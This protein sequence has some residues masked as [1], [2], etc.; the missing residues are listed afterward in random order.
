MSDGCIQHLRSPSLQASI[1]QLVAITCTPTEAKQGWVWS[2]SGWETSWEIRCCC[3]KS[4]SEA[5]RVCS[6]CESYNAPVEINKS[7]NSGFQL[8]KSQWGSQLGL[9]HQTRPNKSAIRR[10]VKKN[11]FLFT[12]PHVPNMFEFLSSV[13]Y[14]KYILKNVGAQKVSVPFVHFH[15]MDRK[16]IGSQREPN[17][18]AYQHSSKYI[19][20]VLHKIGRSC[21]ECHESE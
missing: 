6:S 14:I 19:C 21:L 4:V 15:Y 12:H 8:A 16:C 7:R 18:F 11:Q 9:Q 10:H 20:H 13:E 5:G 3:W 1:Y 2:V 17:L